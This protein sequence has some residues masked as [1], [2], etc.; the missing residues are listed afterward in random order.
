M[1]AL[2]AHAYLI[3]F[4]K[5]AVGGLLSLAVPP[6]FEIER[7]FYR[8]TATVYLLAACSI[9]AGE[10]YLYLGANPPATLMGATV[11]GWTVF[12]LL[13]FV[14]CVTLFIDLPRLR[15]RVF[16]CA[17]ACGAL[18]LASTAVGYLPDAVSP[19]AALPIAMALLAG[20]AACGAATTG[21]LLGHWYLIETG[22]DVSP[23]VRI[24]RYCRACIATE[25]GVVA[26]ATLLLYAWP[27][28]PFQA[29]FDRAASGRFELLG[30][31]R[32]GAWVLAL[33]VTGLIGRTLAIPQT[34][35][36]TGLFY[37]AALVVAVGQICSQWLLFRT[38]LPL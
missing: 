5:L 32:M 18:A 30:L 22:L 1:E 12:T 27:G 21:M 37:V 23:L 24:L 8:S 29:A 31:A 36:A 17:I 4:G 14:Y 13:F 34:M 7:G 28:S 9:S 26:A 25:I 3:L 15:A 2:F 38:E 6:F 19:L 20:A 33:V 11:V 10:T 16:P 35:A